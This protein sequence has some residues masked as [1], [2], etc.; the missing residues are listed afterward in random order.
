MELN[1]LEVLLYGIVSG[2][3]EFLPVSAQAHQM[4]LLNLFGCS[5]P[6]YLLNFFVHIGIYAALLVTSGGYIKRMYNEYQLSKHNRRRR[7][8]ELNMQSVFDIR[9]VKIACVPV[10]VSFIFYVKTF[11]WA[12]KTPIVALFMLLNGILLLIPMYMARGNKDSRHMS[13]FDG[14]LFGIGSALS[15]FPG[16]SRIGGGYNVAVMRGA[17][18]QHAYKWTLILSVPVLL[19]LT[20]FD[21]YFVFAGG[22]AQLD[23]IFLVKCLL[24]GVCAYFSATLAI[25]FLKSLTNRTGLAAFSYYCWGVALFAFILYLY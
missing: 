20:C 2:I 4:I 13:A 17:D 5:D 18:P 21:L 9:L 24:S 12:D 23:L 14:I 25:V 15:V 7:K 19:V 3:T 22:V 6:N 1:W 11:H 16:V 8:R 10:L